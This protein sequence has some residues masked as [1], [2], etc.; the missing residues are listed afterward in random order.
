MNED[1]WGGGRLRMK[2]VFQTQKALNTRQQWL[3]HQSAL[4]KNAKKVPFY[5]SARSVWSCLNSTPNVTLTER[6]TSCKPR[7]KLS[8]KDICMHVHPHAVKRSGKGSVKWWKKLVVCSCMFWALCGLS[9][10]LWDIWNLLICKATSSRK[11]ML[12]NPKRAS[13]LSRE[14]CSTLQMV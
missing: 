6:P 9:E 14:Q 7:R 10:H 5:N 3:P 11:G 8:L 13:N 1:V 4:Q 12:H 2:A